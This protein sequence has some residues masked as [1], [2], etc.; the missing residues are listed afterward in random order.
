MFAVRPERAVPSDVASRAAAATQAPPQVP[1]AS[2]LDLGKAPSPE[3]L[4]EWF[5]TFIAVQ[6]AA[7]GSPE[8][9]QQTA[10]AVV[11]LVGLDRGMVILRAP[12]SGPSAGL[13]GAA[14]GANRW[15]VQ[16]RW[17][18]PRSG[19]QRLFESEPLPFDPVPQMRQMRTVQV[20]FDPSVPDGPYWMDLSFL[21]P[22]GTGPD[23]TVVSGP[24]RRG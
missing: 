18:D 4:M 17:Q 20:Q 16:A 14:A 10:E 15:M 6:R 9:Y 11:K 8:F 2:L 13:G 7:A 24:V 3:K 5:E 12:R 21:E 1:Q 22:P 19:V 23:A